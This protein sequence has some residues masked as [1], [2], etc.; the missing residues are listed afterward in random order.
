MNGRIKERTRGGCAVP[1][2]ERLCK[3]GILE[4]IDSSNNNN[5]KMKRDGWALLQTLSRL[6]STRQQ[7]LAIGVIIHE[8]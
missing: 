3:L 6:H 2:V 7:H 1:I 8:L 5:N 4:L